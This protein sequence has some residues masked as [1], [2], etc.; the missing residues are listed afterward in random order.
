MESVL[1]KT[2]SPPFCPGQRA[3]R[4]RSVSWALR[5]LGLLSGSLTAQEIRL[6]AEEGQLTGLTVASAPEGYSGEGYVKGFIDGSQFVEWSFDA[7]AGFYDLILGFRTPSGEKEVEVT[8]DGAGQAAMLPASD[9][10]SVY[11][12]GLV[13]LEA[14]AH[15]LRV[16]AGWNYYEI[17]FVALTPIA[18]PPGLSPVEA[19]P[20]N[21][22]ASLPA[23]RLLAYLASQYGEVTLTGQQE[24]HD[25]AVIERVAGQRPAILAGDLISYSPTRVQYGG[26]PTTGDRYGTTEEYI[27]A[28]AEGSIISLAWHWNAPADLL[29][30]EGTEWWRGFYEEATTFDLPGA[31]ADR[32]GEDFSAILRDIDAIAVELQKLE[33]AG[34]PVLWR[35]LHEAEGGWFWWGAHGPAALK[36]L[37]EVLYER[38]THF[39][40]LD[41]LLWVYTYTVTVDP[42]WYPGDAMVD[43][44]GVDA[45]P[46]D[47]STALAA[48]WKRLHA[49]YDGRKLL[50][51]SEF[52]G[53]PNLPVM[54][55]LGVRWAYFVSWEGDEHGPQSA[56]ADLLERVYNDPA[57]IVLADSDS[58]QDGVP[59]DV[60]TYFG[61]DWQTDLPVLLSTPSAGAPPLLLFAAGIDPA[62]VRL[63]PLVQMGAT[64]PELALP[65]WQSHDLLT[66]SE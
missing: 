38:L 53:V 55:S 31:L 47:R 12:L 16:G 54:H 26:Y 36:E 7:A 44:V 64:G 42:A 34:V 5:L 59:N 8:L 40:G 4:R 13:R 3:A 6:E 27:A 32:E 43:I 15:T 28:H 62:R 60:A 37:W 41:N 21:P 20:V 22:A 61:L 2:L 33:E 9:D 63:G 51:L 29:N 57:A 24:A 25:L 17:D 35:P 39:H 45:Y 56:P 11:D 30:G 52:G 48:L 50:A 65:L 58:N 1:L 49:L 66:W 10:F 23:R 46:A 18:S 19:V 14:G